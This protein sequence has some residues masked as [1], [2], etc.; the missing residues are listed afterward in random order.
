MDIC[1]GFLRIFLRL[2]R[3]LSLAVNKTIA[4]IVRVY[5]VIF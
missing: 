2:S 4:L 5:I 1:V 3:R